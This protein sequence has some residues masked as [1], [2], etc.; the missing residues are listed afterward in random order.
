MQQPVRHVLGADAQG[1]A[2]LH[3]A[4]VVDVR[5]F[6]TT[7]ALVHPAH[8]IAENALGV[9]VQFFA[10]F[11][12]AP[13]LATR[14]GNREQ[15]GERRYGFL[16]AFGLPREHVHGVVVRGVQRRR[17]GAGDPRSV[18]TG[19]WVAHL[20]LQHVRHA[21][22]HGPHAFA[23]LC[24]A[25]KTASQA[26]LD[27]AV[28]I[29]RN[30]CGVLDGSL[31][32]HRA[33]LHGGMH[34]I[35]GA[36]KETGVDEHDA[37]FHGMDA[38]REVRR[39]AAFFIHDADL[40]GMPRQ[41]QQVF[42]GIEETVAERGFLGA[43]HLGFHDV[44]AAGTA[45]A[46]A[47][48]AQQVVLANQRCHGRIQNAFRGLAAVGQS[49]CR[50][51]HQVAHVAY[52]QQAAARQRERRAIH[53]G[54]GAVRREAPH[55]FTAALVE[56]GFQRAL[57]QA[58]PMAI[59]LHLVGGIHGRHGV[60]E[61]D[62][63]GERGFEQHI[64]QARRVGGAYGVAAVHHQ[65]D[66]Q[67][68]VTQ[69]EVR[70]GAAD[71]LRGVAQGRGGAVPVGPATRR[72]RHGAVEEGPCCGNDLRTAHGVI[73][74]SAGLAWQRIRAV[75]GVVQAA[76]ARVGSV[77]Y[78]ARIQH[79][80]HELG[81]GD[82]GHFS[83]DPFRGD[84][85]WRGLVHQIADV[86]QECRCGCAIRLLACRCAVPVVDEQLQRF[87][88]LQQRRVLRGEA[89]VE[90]CQALPEGCRCHTRARQSAFFDELHQFT[91]HL[92]TVLVLHGHFLSRVHWRVVLGVAPCSAPYS[93]LD[94]CSGLALG[95]Q[96][97]SGNARQRAE[98][99]VVGSVASDADGTD[100]LAFCAHHDD[101]ASSR[102]QAVRVEAGHGGDERRPLGGHLADAPAGYPKTER[103]AGFGDGN[104]RPQVG[105]AVFATQRN[106]VAARV[107]HGH[108][109]RLQ[110]QFPALGE[111]GVKGGLGLVER[112]AVHGRGPCGE[113]SWPPG[114]PWRNSGWGD[115][116]S[117]SA[118]VIAPLHNR[119]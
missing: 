40:D 52:E 19:A 118:T 74:F 16:A 49:H 96:P 44:N 58:Q 39:G 105:G 10:D 103:A 107:Q 34:F 47:A 79:R 30:P 27:I 75:V 37:V 25:G 7:N 48:V 31:A 77:Q 68:V 82:A 98:F 67:A 101:T 106:Q 21:V 28:F 14:H 65:F 92:Q 29:G 50:R 102:Q 72:E 116:P 80:H 46:Y 113:F 114:G 43:M 112:N 24:A 87:A 2:V 94:F 53:G 42:H 35:A 95:L 85:E 108:A 45:V 61:V 66:M 93:I 11:C 12:R 15:R 70:A 90:V 51:G 91:G 36:V 41:F 69:E 9:V 8:H 89:R 100:G 71:E 63:G 110:L 88:L 54:I 56:A 38:G 57:H 3:Q 97:G 60:F 64:G 22:G 86:P 33:R 32:Q 111:G 1:G 117:A 17:G 83:V 55:Q 26:N 6:G 62:D 84:G 20:L 81:A 99:V 4:D 78:E 23:Y 76:P 5:H 73:A 115:S 13:V 109:E 18:G 119:R 59:G 104:L